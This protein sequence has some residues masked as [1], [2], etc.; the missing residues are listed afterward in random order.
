MRRILEL[1]IRQT[2]MYQKAKYPPE[3]GTGECHE[4]TE[5]SREQAPVALS[6]GYRRAQNQSFGPIDPWSCIDVCSRG[7][8]H[9]V[10]KW[11]EMSKDSIP[12]ESH[13]MSLE[14]C[15]NSGVICVK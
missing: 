4:D 7:K 1:G 14:S 10:R 8:R 3:R 15:H 13:N 12:D 6:Q 5:K 2:L 9:C 11:R